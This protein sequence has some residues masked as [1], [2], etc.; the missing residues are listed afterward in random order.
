M[1][2]TIV[3]FVEM[4]VLVFA[5]LVVTPDQL[6]YFSGNIFIPGHILA[7]IGL[8]LFSILLIGVWAR[9]RSLIMFYLIMAG[10]R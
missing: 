4:G 9:F 2:S 3:A 8:S 1:A 5:A 10:F 7:M 6:K